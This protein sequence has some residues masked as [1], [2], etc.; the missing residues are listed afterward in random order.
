MTK[1]VTQASD[2]HHSGSGENLVTLESKFTATLTKQGIKDFVKVSFK[3]DKVQQ[4]F[5]FNPNSN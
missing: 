5:I 3:D 1:L 2:H 4:Y